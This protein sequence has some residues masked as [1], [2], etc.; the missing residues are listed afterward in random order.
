MKL[1][2][3]DATLEN[4]LLNMYEGAGEEFS[5]RNCPNHSLHTHKSVPDSSKRINGKPIEHK[6]KFKIFL[7][8]IQSY[9][10]KRM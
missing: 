7:V 8:Y 1:S 4:L 9:R 6:K 5:A 10:C 2:C 3:T